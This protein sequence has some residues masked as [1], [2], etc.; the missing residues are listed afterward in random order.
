MAQIALILSKKIK[1]PKELIRTGPLY[2]DI[3]R[4]IANRDVFN[5]AA[6]S[7]LVTLNSKRTLL[8]LDPHRIIQGFKLPPGSRSVLISALMCTFLFPTR[9]MGAVGQKC[10]ISGV[11]FSGMFSRV[12]GASMLKHI[13][14]TS[15]SGQDNGL[16]RS[17]SS[18]PA[19][20]QSTSSTCYFR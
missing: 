16:S 10:F 20:S 5:M 8:L 18:W 12:S 7:Q 3:L 13:T 2:H 19:V 4:C 15:V 6:E 14:I 17:Q 11:H 1:L 9:T